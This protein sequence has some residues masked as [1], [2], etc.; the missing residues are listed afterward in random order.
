MVSLLAGTVWTEATESGS[1][2]WSPVK[3]TKSMVCSPDE[4]P[5]DSCVVTHGDLVETVHVMA[6]CT[7]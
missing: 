4:G 7:L 6:I 3:V 2:L 1:L 5:D